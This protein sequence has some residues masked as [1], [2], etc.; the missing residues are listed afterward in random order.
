MKLFK[1]KNLKVL[2]LLVLSSVSSLGKVHHE[3]I[4]TVPAYEDYVGAFQQQ[5][6]DLGRMQI[7]KISADPVNSI[8]EIFG[9]DILVDL[10]MRFGIPA[11][12]DEQ[13]S[14][15]VKAITFRELSSYV[16]LALTAKGQKDVTNNEVMKSFFDYTRLNA[17]IRSD[18]SYMSMGWDFRLYT[19]DFLMETKDG[20]TL[21]FKNFLKRT[22]LEHRSV[23]SI[24]ANAFHEFFKPENAQKMADIRSEFA[25]AGSQLEWIGGITRA[26]VQKLDPAATDPHGAFKA[27]MEKIKTLIAEGQISGIDITGSIVEDSKKYKDLEDKIEANLFERFQ[28][29]F[30]SLSEKKSLGQLK[31]HMYESTPEGEFYDIFFAALKDQLKKK[32]VDGV[33][34]VIRTG[35]VNALRTQD[36][37]RFKEF[38][39]LKDRF[40][41]E[42]NLDSN[43]NLKQ[44]T[45]EKIAKIINE[46][47]AEGFKVR[48]G[49]DGIGIFG[50]ISYF[51]STLQRLIVGGLS[52][53]A[54]THLRTYSDQ[55]IYDN[56]NYKRFGRALM[57]H[58]F[59]K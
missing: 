31:I 2:V 48:L 58:G 4:S 54:V 17:H 20:A 5:G 13:L 9:Q 14:E 41:F 7:S 36:I 40:A 52:K 49:T 59:Y 50:R 43:M 34:P 44:A 24:T 23:V 32:G 15:K 11:G 55:P 26:Q 33:P 28:I 25:K 38:P 22:P 12:T 6:N 39:E 53:D 10:K 37:A 45:P 19:Q 3:H 42:A 1:S 47:I 35:H 8:G 30:D 57:C 56:P 18:W 27:T 51:E 29:I 21:L 46:L 16:R